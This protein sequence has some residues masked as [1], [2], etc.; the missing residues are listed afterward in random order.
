MSMIAGKNKSSTPGIHLKSKNALSDAVLFFDAVNTA[1]DDTKLTDDS[2]GALYWNGTDLIFK[3]GSS[4]TTIGGSGGGSTPTWETL[5]GSDA[6]FTITPDTTFTVAGNRATAT[7]VV[8][9]TNIAGGSG[10]MGHH[11][12]RCSHICR[13]ICIRDNISSYNDRSCGLDFA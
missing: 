8:T 10:Y 1:P 2:V 6:T 12:S 7:D 9:L 3:N 13:S 5:F 11:K 4:S